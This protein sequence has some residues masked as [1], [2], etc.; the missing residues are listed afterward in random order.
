MLPGSPKNLKGLELSL[1][2][3]LL[4][5]ADVIR[6]DFPAING[7]KMKY[8]VSSTIKCAGEIHMFP[9]TGPHKVSYVLSRSQYG[10]H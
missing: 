1:T 9:D 7:S 6:T 8:D 2:H 4:V 3:Q 10:H 5:Y